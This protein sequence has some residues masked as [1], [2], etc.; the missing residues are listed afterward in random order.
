M[1][2]WLVSSMKPDSV[3]KSDTARV[4]VCL[5]SFHGDA[6]GGSQSTSKSLFV[7]PSGCF[8]PSPGRNPS[9][10]PR[11]RGAL[12]FSSIRQ[13]VCETLHLIPFHPN[14]NQ[15]R[16]KMFLRSCV[17]ALNNVLC[18]VTRGLKHCVFSHLVPSSQAR[19]SFNGDDKERDPRR[20]RR[21]SLRIQEVRPVMLVSQLL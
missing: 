16:T 14:T 7:F 13:S 6:R 19:D 5:S 15:T 20:R 3:R 2:L 12:R 18:H 9:R 11:T 1:W 17:A 21:G 4:K 10:L 8:L